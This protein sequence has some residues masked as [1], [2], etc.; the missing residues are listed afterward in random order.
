MPAPKSTPALRLALQRA[1]EKTPCTYDQLMTAT[2]LP[3]RSVARWVT[4]MRDINAVHIS[5]WAPDKNGRLFIA[6]F[7]WGTGDDKARPGAKMTAAER[8][9][10]LRAKRNPQTGRSTRIAKNDTGIGIDDLI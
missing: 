1:L 9:R 7:A 2:G 6:L 8:M 4:S 3:Q 5:G 10:T